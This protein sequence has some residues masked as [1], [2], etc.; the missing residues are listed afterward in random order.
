MKSKFELT[1]NGSFLI[2]RK[3]LSFPNSIIVEYI[4]LLNTDLLMNLVGYSP[5][6]LLSFN[7]IPVRNHI[8]V[9]E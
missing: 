7:A 4:Y 3:G 6:P 1:V 2:Q 8:G 9:V 5:V